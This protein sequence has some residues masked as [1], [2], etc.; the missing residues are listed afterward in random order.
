MKCW[1]S[2]SFHFHGGRGQLLIPKRF[3]FFRYFTTIPILS[4]RRVRILLKRTE[5]Q[6]FEP[7]ISCYR[8]VTKNLNHHYRI[9][10][11][12]QE[13]KKKKNS[14]SII[15]K[16]PNLN[17]SS[18]RVQKNLKEQNKTSHKILPQQ[19]S[20]NQRINK[21][22]RKNL[23][24]GRATDRLFATYVRISERNPKHHN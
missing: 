17:L 4:E 21:I 1:F 19:H 9:L 3:L 15:P 16:W 8:G 10:Q 14:Q 22:P 11:L 13:K 2:I 18:N 7:Q 6:L 24:D 5:R 23:T 12:T 20:H